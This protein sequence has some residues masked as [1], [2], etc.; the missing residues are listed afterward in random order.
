MMFENGCK[1]DYESGCIVIYM[2]KPKIINES[3][4][5]RDITID[6][7]HLGVDEFV[8]KRGLTMLSFSGVV[9]GRFSDFR[10]TIIYLRSRITNEVQSL[11]D[12]YRKC[13][14]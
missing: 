6:N 14:R 8:N 11:S 9:R 12:K 4:K 13:N 5:G 1:Y 10:S 3:L 7:I 2:N